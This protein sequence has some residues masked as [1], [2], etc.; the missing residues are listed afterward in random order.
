M[1]AT[2]IAVF[3]GF[4]IMSFIVVDDERK[5]KRRLDALQARFDELIEASDARSEIIQ[6]MQAGFV[7]EFERLQLLMLKQILHNTTQ[8]KTHEQ[9]TT[10]EPLDQSTCNEESTTTVRQD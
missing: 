6:Q 9:T 5:N 1:E 10:E 2:M 3:I 7:S 4:A 8:E